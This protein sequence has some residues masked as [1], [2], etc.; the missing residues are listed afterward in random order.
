MS[1]GRDARAPFGAGASARA[2]PVR[3]IGETVALLVGLTILAAASVTLMVMVVPAHA[4][5]G[6]AGVTDAG[7]EVRYFPASEVQAAFDK[8]AV[9]INAGT[10]MVHASRRDAVGKAEV[11][12]KDTDIIHVLKGEATIVT[13][14]SVV[15]G[16]PTAEGEMRG[17]SIENGT[18]RHLAEGDVLVVPNGMPHWFSEVNG[19]F[20]YYVVKVR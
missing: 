3:T 12:L 8:G 14:G 19:T 5:A 13:G 9:L 1:A 2:V 16:Q 10:Y 18:T 17:A 4:A 20:L 7:P 11:H 15:G 6:T